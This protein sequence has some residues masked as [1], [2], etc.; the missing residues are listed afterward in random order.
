MLRRQVLQ[1]TAQALCPVPVITT[2]IAGLQLP[3]LVPL[4]LEVAVTSI[5]QNHLLVTRSDISAAE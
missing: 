4:C 5:E 2:G 3:G 1:P